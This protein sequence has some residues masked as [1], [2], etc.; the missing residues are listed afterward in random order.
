MHWVKVHWIGTGSWLHYNVKA[1]GQKAKTGPII[2]QN[3]C[4]TCIQFLFLQAA[5]IEK[6]KTTLNVKNIGI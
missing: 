6:E 4:H 3:M 5:T 1:V 2:A